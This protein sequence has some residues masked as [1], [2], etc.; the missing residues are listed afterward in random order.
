MTAEMK[1]E[2]MNL[3]LDIYNN[4]NNSP[5]NNHGNQLFMNIKKPMVANQTPITLQ[6]TNRA[7]ATPAR[8]T[9]I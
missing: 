8:N 3:L 5:A 9:N 6:I 1:A 4:R 2:R 7:R